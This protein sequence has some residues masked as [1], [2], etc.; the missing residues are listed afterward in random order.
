[1]LFS[2]SVNFVCAVMIMTVMELYWEDRKALYAV[3]VMGR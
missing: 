2:S 3:M 1:M